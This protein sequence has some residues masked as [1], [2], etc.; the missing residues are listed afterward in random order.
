[1]IHL[2]LLIPASFAPFCWGFPEV[3]DVKACTNEWRCIFKASTWMR[4][5]D[6]MLKAGCVDKLPLQSIL[7]NLCRSSNQGLR[8][9]RGIPRRP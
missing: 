5:M 3:N 1:M 2:A 4:A 6:R 8:A 9:S 7:T